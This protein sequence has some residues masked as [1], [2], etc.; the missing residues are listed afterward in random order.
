MIIFSVLFRIAYTVAGLSPDRLA[1]LELADALGIHEPLNEG[2]D[3]G[4][5]IGGREEG[6]GV[7]EIV[8]LVVLRVIV[9]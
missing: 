4:M 9:L 6:I 8:A 2:L 5:G 1:E 7:P 3:S